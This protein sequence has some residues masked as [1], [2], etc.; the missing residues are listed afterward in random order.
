MW[1]LTLGPIVAI[2]RIIFEFCYFFTHNYG[3]S[4]LLLSVVT[5][6]L[7]IPLGKWAN[8]IVLKQRK[9]ENILKPQIVRIKENLQGSARHEAIGRLYKRYRYNPLQAVLGATG[10][11]VQL[12]FLI[13][14]FYMLSEFSAIQGVSFGP[15]K[16][17][18][19]PDSLVMHSINL[20]PILM[21]ILNMATAFINSEF[22]RQERSQ[23]YLIAVLFLFLLYKAPSSLLVYWTFNNLISFCKV[24]LRRISNTKFISDELLNL[25]KDSDLRIIIGL[26]I[27]SIFFLLLSRLNSEPLESFGGYAKAIS[28][29]LLLIDIIFCLFLLKDELLKLKNNLKFLCAIGIFLLTL[30]SIV[31]FLSIYG[32]DCTGY[33]FSTQLFLNLFFILIFKFGEVIERPWKIA[34]ERGTQELFVPIGILTGCFVFL[35]YPFGLYNSDPSAFF[36]SW[37]SILIRQFIYLEV[38][39][40]VIYFL[41]YFFGRKIKIISILIVISILI[42]SFIWNFW[43]DPKLGALSNY[44][45]QHSDIL[46][47][48]NFGKVYL[49][50]L[51]IAVLCSIWLL[52]RTRVDHIKTA[53][54]VTIITLLFYPL[55]TKN[56]ADINLERPQNINK[57]ISPEL[58]ELLTF[59]KQGKNIIVIMLDMFSPT[60]M[61]LI[62]K[63]DPA[64]KKKFSSFVWY[65]D[66]LSSGISTIF[67]KAPLLGGEAATA[68]VLNR[69]K[70][71][72]LE[73]KVNRSW[74]VFFEKLI[75]KGYNIELNDNKWYA[76]F[77]PKYYEKNILSNIIVNRDETYLI[78]KWDD[79]NE[80]NVNIQGNSSN[81]LSLYGVFKISPFILKKY[82]YD[83]GK[84]LN[85]INRSDDIEWSHRELP[86][87]DALSSQII[88]TDLKKD[89]FKFVSTLL[90]H[91]PWNLN[92]Y[93]KPS[94]ETVDQDMYLSKGITWNS[95]LQT[96][97]CSLQLIASFIDILKEK[98][99]F[100]NT[101]ILI[102]SDHGVQGANMPNNIKNLSQ[103]QLRDNSLLLVK[104]FGD[105][106]RELII[107]PNLTTNYDVPLMIENAIGLNKEEPW[108]NPSR[109][110]K[111]VHGDWQRELHHK[112]FFNIKEYFTVKGT[113]FNG[114]NWEKNSLN[115]F[116]Y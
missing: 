32:F 4:L 48:K 15:I 63:A 56:T 98:G 29:V 43:N 1:D 61:E 38:S 36:Q 104:E 58:K 109:S 16:N 79:R 101:M 20:L 67:G 10:V 69:D 76:W 77:D 72:S 53:C 6:L 106:K 97:L 7:M 87:L 2:Y 111:T 14:A 66:T 22:N 86:I 12:P 70:S 45:F 74:S 49:F 94:I 65:P 35:Y 88:I 85:K 55:I 54:W 8:F 68:W 59:S 82:I 108:K 46:L 50:F 89:S 23:A 17:L 19:E 64:L 5:S 99:L 39:I 78:E 28:D 75:E 73:E 90:T 110:R 92:A 34:E 25:N 116:V 95:R 44:E 60:D 84:W 51:I 52:I 91:A 114:V 112:N 18:A 113:L 115:N 102:A 13:G 27:L 107:S 83:G 40:L 62:L 41:N 30:S 11:L 21:T 47:N 33:K 100:E 9:I 80:Y 57:S 103:D 42:A 31:R 71:H 26:P 96:E 37:N 24:A 3:L 93:C 81:F 105:N